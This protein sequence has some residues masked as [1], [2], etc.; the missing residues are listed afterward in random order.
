M[1]FREL[2]ILGRLVGFDLDSLFQNQQ[3]TQNSFRTIGSIELIEPFWVHHGTRMPSYYAAPYWRPLRGG[4]WKPEKYERRQ[5]LCPP[6]DQLNKATRCTH[7]VEAGFVSRSCCHESARSSAISLYS[8][9]RFVA[10]LTRF[11]TDTGGAMVLNASRAQQTVAS[12]RVTAVYSS[13]VIE[14]TCHVSIELRGQSQETAD[15]LKHK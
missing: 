11:W 15:G 5:I 13:H 10:Q 4:G 6:G 9:L 2:L 7:F 1:T 3:L 14:A 12:N 8:L